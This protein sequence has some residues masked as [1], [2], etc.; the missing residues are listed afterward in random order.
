MLLGEVIGIIVLSSD[1][2][3]GL[4]EAKADNEQLTKEVQALSIKKNEL[5]NKQAQRMVCYNYACAGG[6]TCFSWVRCFLN[7][8]QFDWDSLNNLPKMVH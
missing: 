8:S 6:N 7:C 5:V 3:I 4:Q 2:H 1:N